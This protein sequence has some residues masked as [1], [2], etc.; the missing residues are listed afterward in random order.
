MKL[1]S[2]VFPAFGMQP[3]WRDRQG[4]YGP[5]A[6]HH[7]AEPLVDAALLRTSTKI[8]FIAHLALGDFTYM[9]SCFRAFARAF[10][11]IEIHLWVDERRRTSDASQ[12]PH[13]QKYA[14]YD[15]LAE[16]TCFKKVYDQTYSPQSYQRSIDEAQ[17]EHYPIVVSLATLERH[18]YARLGP[19]DQPGRIR[20][21][22]KKSACAFTIS[23]STSSTAASTR[24]SRRIRTRPIPASTSA[25]SMRPGSTCCS[26]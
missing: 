3:V 5:S 23:P 15:W 6:T 16:S 2:D 25:R 22:A 1:S 26:A 13:L 17:R 24:S 12:W 14:L 9:Q 4:A 21:P 11:H 8:L 10:P 20:G 19:P 18:K 7:E